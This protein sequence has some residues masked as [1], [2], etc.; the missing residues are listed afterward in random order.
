MRQNRVEI[1][2]PAEL[3]PLIESGTIQP[4]IRANYHSGKGTLQAAMSQ[5]SSGSRFVSA[6]IVGCRPQGNYSDREHE[7]Q[8]QGLNHAAKD[9]AVG[10][11]PADVRSIN[12]CRYVL[13]RMHLR[14]RSIG[15]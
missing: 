7:S 9:F 1:E 4:V 15:V 5:T 6:K 2:Q 11:S 13:H 10:A 3:D 14:G 12:G 8:Q